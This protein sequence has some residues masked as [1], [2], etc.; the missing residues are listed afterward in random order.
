MKI[1][2]I[3]YK[4]NS[5]TTF[6]VTFTPS[7]FEKLF[8]IKE[9]EE[10]YKDTGETYHYGGGVVYIKKNG[11]YLGNGNYIGVAIDNWRRSW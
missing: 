2:E 4:R 11:E 10:E 5:T 8:G 6:V 1:K 3:K 7:W 9:Q